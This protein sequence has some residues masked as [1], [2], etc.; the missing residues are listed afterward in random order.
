MLFVYLNHQFL[1]YSQQVHALIHVLHY[2]MCT[3]ITLSTE[4]AGDDSM[5]AWGSIYDDNIAIKYYEVATLL[6]KSSIGDDDKKFL[7]G[8]NGFGGTVEVM[9][10]LRE[11]LCDWGSYKSAD[12]FMTKFLL[13]DIYE[14]AK[15][16]EDVIESAAILTEFRKQ[17]DLIEP[18]ATEVTQSMETSNPSGF[19]RAEDFLKN[20]MSECGKGVSSIDSISSWMQLM[21][22]TGLVH[23]STLSYSRMT[24]IPEVWRWI[25]I[26]NDTFS[27][28]E[29]DQMFVIAAT[30][31]GMSLD[32]H[33][34]T[35]E[36]TVGTPWDTSKFTPEIREVMD[37]YNKKSND[38][39][40]AY[41]KEIE[42]RPDFRDYGWILTD[43]CPDGYD[44]KQYTITT[45]I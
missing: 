17:V 36:V 44:G 23:G 10:V 39:K 27:D 24:L 3:A 14:T 41:Q 42:K 16:P 34:F 21:S 43:H 32:R 20:F 18:Y 11:F 33:V 9:K 4:E 37:K 15:N 26:S 6:F 45:Y 19:K 31:Q 28:N 30:M 12:D 7:T 1:D 2:L 22:C 38:L 29:I 40:V 13:S 8:K 35:S 5:E 25:D